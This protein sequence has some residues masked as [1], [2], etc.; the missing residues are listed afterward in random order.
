MS[1]ADFLARLSKSLLQDQIEGSLITAGTFPVAL[2]QRL[3]AYR[4]EERTAKLKE[5]AIADQVVNPPS[6]AELSAYFNKEQETI[7][8]CAAP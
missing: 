5:I 1:E 6:D 4:L 7:T 8:A 2:T 3:S